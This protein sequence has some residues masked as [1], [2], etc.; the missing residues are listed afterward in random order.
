MPTNRP[1]QS[2]Y[3]E[4]YILNN[5]YDEDYDVVAV[6]TLGEDSTNGVLRRIQTNS[7]GQLL[8]GTEN[9]SFTISNA[10][11][12]EASTQTI[13]KTLNGSVYEKIISFNAGGD[14]IAVSAWVLVSGGDSY[15]LLEDGTDKRLLEDGSFLLLEI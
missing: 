9:A 8:V 14:T 12:V 2:K 11:E 1:R 5:T 10:D 7:D 15:R 3:S 6:E 4:Q 13:T